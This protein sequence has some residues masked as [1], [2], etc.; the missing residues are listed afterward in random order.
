M[1]P[2]ILKY[3]CE[4]SEKW[5]ALWQKGK[6]DTKTW[7]ICKTGVGL[8]TTFP[9]WTFY[10]IRIEQ[11]NGNVKFTLT[12]WNYVNFSTKDCCL[13]IF[14]RLCITWNRLLLFWSTAVKVTILL[15]YP[16]TGKITGNNIWP[17]NFTWSMYSVLNNMMMISFSCRREQEGQRLAKKMDLGIF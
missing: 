11:C 8:Q 7:L 5:V 2:A 4:K 16:I 9:L 15:C 6:P 10:R 1:E 17:K 14:T 12:T 13:P 3:Q